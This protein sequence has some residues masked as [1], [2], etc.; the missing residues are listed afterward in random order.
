MLN[1][2]F[3]TNAVWVIPLPVRECGEQ[4]SELKIRPALHA[5]NVLQ[6]MPQIS[7]PVLSR[8][9]FGIKAQRK[10]DHCKSGYRNLDLSAVFAGL[11]DA[12]GA[13]LLPNKPLRPSENK[14]IYTDVKLHTG[15]L[16]LTN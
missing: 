9:S 11:R 1:K 4:I 14:W 7:S 16:L 2:P 5:G 8:H 3:M 10:P 6:I 13:L 15:N 12:A